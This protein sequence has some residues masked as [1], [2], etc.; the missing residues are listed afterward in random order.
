[1]GNE[2]AMTGSTAGRPPTVPDTGD[3]TP[4]H[5]LT[6]PA[7]EGEP[8]PPLRLRL[9]P[10]RAAYDPASATL[11]VADVHIGKAAVFRARGLPVPRGTTRATLERLSQAVHRSGASRLVVLGD[12]LHARESQAAGTLAALSDWR[13]RH[14]ALECLVV[15]GNHDRHAG[16][17]QEDLGIRT[18]DGPYLHG[19]LRGVHEPDDD[20]DDP[21]T[22]GPPARLTLAG[23]VH[24]VVHLGGRLDRLRL[25]C[26]WLRGAV[27]TLPAFGE[28]TGGHRVD[29]RDPLP[30]HFFVVSDTV[31]PLPMTP[32]TMAAVKACPRLR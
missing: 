13:A 10:E 4:D 8:A 2:D 22:A 11:F 6:L 29:R 18:L 17:V 12:F 7:R 20:A 15:E 16:R 32:P 27:L 9:M 5:W 3:D 14:A 24:P 21:G 1:M 26:F 19:G 30:Q 28:F 31:R 23:H 25:P